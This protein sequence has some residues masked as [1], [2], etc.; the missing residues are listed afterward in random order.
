MF[1]PEIQ[2]IDVEALADK[3]PSVADDFKKAGLTPFQWWAYR[4]AIL[5]A[6]HGQAR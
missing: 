3:Y 6:Y 5:G 4:A 1:R 2:L